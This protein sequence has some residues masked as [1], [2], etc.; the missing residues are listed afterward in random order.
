MIVQSLHSTPIIVLPYNDWGVMSIPMYCITSTSMNS[1]THVCIVRY[2][3]TIR[4][5]CTNV[6]FTGNYFLTS[7]T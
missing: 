1:I 7:P 2:K 6:Q 3:C 4:Y 5:K